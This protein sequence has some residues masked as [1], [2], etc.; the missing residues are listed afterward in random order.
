[1]VAISVEQAWQAAL[2]F[3][4]LG[5][6]QA[7]E[8][9]FR[10]VAAADPARADVW[11]QL[12]VMAGELGHD[13]EA[14]GLLSRAVMLAPEN[15]DAH[16]ELGKSYR[17]WGRSEDA[18]GCFQQAVALRPDCPE[19]R[20]YLGEALGNLGR[21]S[22]AVDSY[23]RAIELRPHLSEAWNNLGASLSELKEFDQ[24]IE[25]LRHALTLN[26]RLNEAYNNLGRALTER[27]EFD[28]AIAALHQALQIKPDSAP[29]YK[30]LGHAL[31]RSGRFEEALDCY[32]HW[33]ALHPQDAT[34]HRSMGHVLLFLGSYAEGWKE[35]QWRTRDPVAPWIH[36]NFSVPL[37]NG[38]PIPGRTLFLYPEQGFGD[39]IHFLRYVPLAAR[40]SRAARVLLECPAELER[41]LRQSCD[42]AVEIVPRRPAHQAGALPAMDDHCPLMSLPFAMRADEPL[43]MEAPYV[44]VPPEWRTAWRERLAATSHGRLRV[45]LAWAGSAVH[46]NDR[47]RSIPA[48]LLRPLLAAHPDIAFYSLQVDRA[49]AD[50]E[51]LRDAGLIDLTAHLTDFAETAALLSELDLVI[52]ADTAAIHLAGALG[53]PVWTLLPF[54]PDWRWGPKRE[55]TP[56]YPTMRLMRQPKP[57]EWEPAIERVSAELP[58]F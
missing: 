54:A 31:F 22:E 4:R 34:A 17:R 55:D 51:P 23:R 37:W 49:G 52:S 26:P 58:S 48:A 43:P 19:M 20:F 45:G 28:L 47:R 27:G 5:Q 3:Q 29:V 57:G 41:L 39:A 38:E 12:G 50:A 11:Y 6:H 21:H 7:A 46:T 32:R 18:V 14:V 40:R 53:R 33:V 9:L 25:C 44:E 16:S 24:A 35:Y 36:R 8:R 13:E 1:M 42:P 30:N 56:W 10:Q 2:S 15:G